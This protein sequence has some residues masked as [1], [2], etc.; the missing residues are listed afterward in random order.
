VGVVNLNL[1]KLYRSLIV[2]DCAL[3]LQDELFLIIEDLLCDGFARP[4][5]AVAFQ[6]HLRLAQNV[7]VSLQRPLRLQKRRAIR[8]GVDVDQRIA[9]VN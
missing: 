5:S 8:A 6:V 7:F 2:F 1:V 9:L 4:R 3:V